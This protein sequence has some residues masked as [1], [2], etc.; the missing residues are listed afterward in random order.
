M[1]SHQSQV[2]NVQ[3]SSGFCQSL[4]LFLAPLRLCLAC[5]QLTQSQE[6]SV[7]IDLYDHL[8]WVARDPHRGEILF[9]WFPERKSQWKIEEKKRGIA[10]L[11]FQISEIC[12]CK[13]TKRS[14]D[15]SVIL[16]NLQWENTKNLHIQ[17]HFYK[18]GC[19]FERRQQQEP[20]VYE[21]LFYRSQGKDLPTKAKSSL[22]W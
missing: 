19:G 5:K 8:H 4:D 11:P 21:V 15:G 1:T 7:Q 16:G 14:P 10:V 9:D 22:F 18:K 6:T 13:M 3:S 20:E 17:D 12:W 2:W